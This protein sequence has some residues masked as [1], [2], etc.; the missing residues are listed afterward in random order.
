MYDKVKS[1]DKYMNQKKEVIPYNSKEKAIRKRQERLNRSVKGAVTMTK[2]E[3]MR[4]EAR[5]P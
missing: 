5:A 3:E 4:E 1:E 2:E